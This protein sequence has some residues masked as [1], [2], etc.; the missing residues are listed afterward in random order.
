MLL[1]LN[2][3]AWPDC[4]EKVSFIANISTMKKKKKQKAKQPFSLTLSKRCTEHLKQEEHRI[5]ELDLQKH[6]RTEWI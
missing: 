3:I 4:R 1:P 6:N 2:A 5:Y